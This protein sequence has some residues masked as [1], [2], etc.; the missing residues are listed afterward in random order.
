[1]LREVEGG[2]RTA[3]G[4]EALGC[5]RGGRGDDVEF[6]AGPVGGHLAAAAGGVSSGADSLEEM[7]FDGGA[8]GQREGAVA[9]VGKEPVVRGAERKGGG[10]EEG[11]VSGAGDLEEDF[12]LIF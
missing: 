2:F 8:E 9:V 12:L 5:G 1:M 4:L 7:L 6:G 3:D 10:D 11:F